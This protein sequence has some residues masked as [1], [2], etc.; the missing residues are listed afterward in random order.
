MTKYL[1]QL[2]QVVVASSDATQD[3]YLPLDQA[4]VLNLPIIQVYSNSLTYYDPE[5]K[6]FHLRAR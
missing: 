2:V 1:Q 4:K 6:F 5:R 3:Y